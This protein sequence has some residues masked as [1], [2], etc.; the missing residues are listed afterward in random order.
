MAIG[1]YEWHITHDA[2][3]IEAA[4]VLEQDRTWNCFALADL[5][6][7]FRTYSQYTLATRSDGAASAAC[8][9]I[10]H[11]AFTVL[12]PYGASD[13]VEAI[14][15][16]LGLPQQT[17]IQ[18]QDEH[19][20]LLRRRY[21]FEAGGRKLLRM[22]VTAQTFRAALASSTLLVE[23]L[24]PNDAAALMEFYKLY[25]GAHF[26]PDQLKY[27][28]FF[29]MRA[30]DGFLAAGG[31]HAVAPTYGIAVLGSIFTHPDAR[32]QGY[33]TAV[34]AALT[35]HLL[36]R[37]CHNVVLNV[38]AD[39]APAIRVYKCL[40]FQTHSRYWTGSGTLRGN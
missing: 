12:S 16:Q 23:R 2:S 17:L 29:G 21:H 13:G 38:L 36:A 26:L 40:G 19:L 9:V 20:P 8:M 11:P 5:L 27:G 31:T 33:A 32:R 4:A 6:P 34:T 28:V 18:A 3:N 10:R 39:N 24:T 30:S 7:P 15:A 35:S 37:G 1:E 25:A 14:L 22:A